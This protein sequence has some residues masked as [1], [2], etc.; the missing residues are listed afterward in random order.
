[1]NDVENTTITNFMESTDDVSRGALRHALNVDLRDSFPQMM[2]AFGLLFV[3][4]AISHALLLTGT[5]RLIMV[6]VATLTAIT[7]FLARWAI[8]RWELPAYW[9]HLVAVGMTLLIL[10]NTLLHLYLSADPLQTTNIILLVI[11]VGFILFSTAWWGFVVALALLGWGIFV[12]QAGPDPAWLHFGFAMVSAVTVSLVVHVVRVR[13]YQ[14]LERLRLHDEGQQVKLKLALQ[15]TE[16]VQRALETTVAVAQHITSILDVEP[17]LN[18][19][20]QLI[21]DSY[22]YYYVGIFLLDETQS[23]LVARA[24]TGEVG[25][26]LSQCG[27]RLELDQESLISWVA[28]HRRAVN[29]PD[30]TQDDRYLFL[31]EVPDTRS[32]LVLPLQIADNLLGV[33]DLQSRKVLAFGQDDVEVLNSLAGQVAIAIQNA[34]QYQ[35][36]RKR[37]MFTERLRDVGKALSRTIVLSQVLDLV[38]DQLVDIVPFD[39]G[40]VML[41]SEGETIIRAAWGFPDA[42]NPLDYRVPIKPGDVFHSMRETQQPVL[43]PDVQQREDWEYLE[44]LPPAR[45]WLGVPLIYEDKVI[46]MLSLTRE[47]PEPYTD[48]EVQLSLAFASQAAVAL[49]NARLYATLSETVQELQARTEDLRITYA[50]LERLDQTK[51]DFISVASHELRTPLTVLN[52]YSQI[53]VDDPKIKESEYH[54]QL[55]EGIHTGTQRLHTIVDSML[56]MAKID[57]RTLQLHPES[58][59]PYTMIHSLVHSLEDTLVQRDLT[60]DLVDLESLP[61]LQADIEALRKVFY[62]LLVNAVKYT[63]NQGTIT[64]SGKALPLDDARLPGGGVEIAVRDTGIGIDPRVH[65]LIF[66]K[67]YQTGEVSLHSTGVT[68]FKGGG[69]GLGLAIARGIVEAHGG[70]IWVESSGYDEEICPGSTFY[71]LLPLNARSLLQEPSSERDVAA[72]QKSE[73]DV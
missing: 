17:L 50:Q 48:E 5:M 31:E 46:G 22:G 67:F 54:Y 13:T 66:A 63:P 65:Q 15:S 11:G 32:E 68:K 26:E 1:M 62:H 9:A 27:F 40:S 61:M 18:Q 10:L 47:H 70:K 12:L 42:A 72:E 14:R 25:H 35:A 3:V 41:E 37:R 4:F 39:R 34:V 29:V 71:I 21:K 44:N 23:Y 64:V 7:F 51:S 73:V 55:V 19:V 60:I 36:E 8:Q 20:V 38:L 49:Q 24:T 2:L 45:S 58:F 30:V 57:S 69:P 33:L 43:V 52:G 56:D 6:A 59:S 28:R 53:L 16:R